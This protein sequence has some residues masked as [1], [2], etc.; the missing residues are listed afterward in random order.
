VKKN[1]NCRTAVFNIL[2]TKTG[3]GWFFFPSLSE[4]KNHPLLTRG[5][6]FIRQ[7]GLFVRGDEIADCDNESL[8]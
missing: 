5:D 6:C 1:K 2:P 3:R 8:P 4:G 7:L